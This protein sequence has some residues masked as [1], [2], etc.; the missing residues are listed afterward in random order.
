VKSLFSDS[1][2]QMDENALLVGLQLP[3]SHLRS[4]AF[5]RQPV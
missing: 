3:V 2:M 5:R 1:L 4:L